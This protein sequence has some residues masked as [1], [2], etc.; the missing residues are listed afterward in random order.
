MG[1]EGRGYGAR[2][3]SALRRDKMAAEGNEAEAEDG[4]GL[5]GASSSPETL[6]GRERVLDF[7]AECSLRTLEPGLKHMFAKCFRR[8][9][10][11]QRRLARCVYDQFL[12][13][14]Q[15]FVKAE[16]QILKEE[17]NLSALLASLDRMAEAAKARPGPAWRPS[18]TP[19]ADLPA[20]LSPC[21][22]VQRR[23]LQASLEKAEARNARLAQAVT[24]G[25][26]EIHRLEE[27]AQ[28]H[29]E[30]WKAIAAEGRE[31]VNALEEVP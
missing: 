24:Q 23:F 15:S 26:Q 12:A 9:Y 5:G 31:R 13:H 21:L 8:L 27:E 10:K 22:V 19:E 30:Q 4:A 28:R 6:P 7:A 17:G 29:R 3:E 25:R 2:F 18:G 14:F 16:I 1:G 11:A 20:L